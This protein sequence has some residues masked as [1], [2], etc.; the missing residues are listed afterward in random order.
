M[1][2]LILARATDKRLRVARYI[3]S[4]VVGEI[5]VVGASRGAA[6]D[7]VRS[8]A[9]LTRATFGL[10]RFS[11]PQLAS[12]IARLHAA[13]DGV[14]P[15]SS[16]MIDALAGHATNVSAS[17]GALRYFTPVATLPGFPL[18][19]RRTVTEL[20]LAQVESTALRDGSTVGR[21]ISEIRDAY[22]GALESFGISDL[23]DLY[24][25]ATEVLQSEP[26]SFVRNA[27]VLLDVSIR[28]VT[29]A[30]F[31]QALERVTE[32][33]IATLPAD[34][35]ESRDAL[36]PLN[37]QL[38]TCDEPL[39]T[40]LD[41]VRANLFALD[42]VS[43][44]EPDRSVTLFSAPGEGREALE[45]ARLIME[46]ARR[47]V[48]FDE[49]AI[50]LRNPK[51]YTAHIET[52]F[53][54]AEIPVYF[55]HGARRPDPAGRAFLALLACGA[56]NLSARRF[57]EY[58]SLGQVPLRAPA[59]SAP[60]LPSDETLAAILALPDEE[61]LEEGEEG[62]LRE[63]WKW[64]QY[65][66]EAAVLGGADRWDRRLTGLAKEYAARLR[67]VIGEDS[68][69][70]KAAALTRD[71]Q[72]LTQLRAFALPLL[73]DLTELNVAQTWGEWLDRLE[74]LARRV[75]RS[76]HRV[77]R[78]LAD[79]RP[80]ATIGPIG[81]G[82]VLAVLANRLG[83][84]E[85]A[86]EPHRFGAVFVAPIDDVR[87]RTFRIVYTPGVAEGVF[88]VRPREDPL[89][90]D[91]IRKPLLEPLIT[92]QG[93]AERERLL[94]QLVTGAASERLY[95]SYARMDV[96]ESRARVSSFYALDVL[97]ALTGGIPDYEE[98]ER[99]AAAVTRA[100]MAW[101]APIDPTLAI[102]P[103]EYDLAILRPFLLET[104]PERVRGRA[105][106]LIRLHPM[107]GRALRTRRARWRATWG[108]GDGFMQLPESTQPLLAPLSLRV[109][110]YSPSSLQHYAACP[111]RFY[112]AALMRLSVR[113]APEVIEA[114][115]PLTRGTLVHDIY[116]AVLRRLRD[117]AL[118][119]VLAQRL[120]EAHALA[121]QVLTAVAAE[122]KEALAPA[123]DLVWDTEISS[124][125]TD[126]HI[127][128]ARLADSS[129]SWTPTYFEL[130]FGL[131]E[132]EG[133]DPASTPEP[134]LV[135]D[136]AFRLRGAI[137]LVERSVTAG[138]LRVR[139]YKTGEDRGKKNL[140]VGFGEILQPTL[141]ALA[142]ENIFGQPV[143]EGQLW[144]ASS[145]GGF[146][147][148]TV[149]LTA[150]SRRDATLVLSTIDTA[151]Q[152]GEF[153]AAPRQGAC[154]Y[155]DFHRVC[156]PYEERRVA[157]KKQD[158]LDTLIRLREL[159]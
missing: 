151:I 108:P 99:G 16:L 87:G 71:M 68:E 89:L 41:R 67:S 75:L 143:V 123:I 80:M 63:P 119:P 27:V 65:I 141:Y 100:T 61:T 60:A 130:G 20:R 95:L 82:D 158:Q 34:D 77:L 72:R 12:R 55:A 156:G 85:P 93:R 78:A 127:W 133:L 121:D 105:N 1:R 17:A 135:T 104:I 43:T 58:L 15:A 33:V 110:P 159:P 9:R 147:E 115:D 97:R 128:L 112:L 101:P 7:F 21:D 45:I 66:V 64:E 49:M 90:L 149:P 76:P 103:L 3:L 150:S 32:R 137:D 153:P 4:A 96:R 70:P 102:D 22:E 38:I 52:A 140:T 91:R 88:P 39:M 138:K 154:E 56:E 35:R 74:P 46:E 13:K 120:E 14:I 155:C 148:R 25:R 84:I 116:A 124:I 81:Y 98:A 86:Q 131:S 117:A 62:A 92:Q 57:A 24:T 6:D 51:Q 129:G 134:A 50:L 19:V 10:H 53:R 8:I 54:R 48:R 36:T 126:M 18:A 30:Q 122:A 5:V 2:Q 73:Q 44:A 40:A 144:Y 109:S 69:S 47:G 94:L 42:P 157:Q 132:S 146:K 111:Y 59:E 152:A 106:Y 107:L 114:L 37:L 145:R 118:L 113:E 28:S 11:L 23:A 29:E 79:L 26:P 139:D 125:R 142:A 136:E 31:I 83:T